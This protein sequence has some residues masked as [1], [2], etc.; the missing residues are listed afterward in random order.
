MRDRLELPGQGAKRLLRFDHHRKHLQSREEA[1]A[2]LDAGTHR[3]IDVMDAVLVRAAGARST[4]LSLVGLGIG[5]NADIM[6]GVD[7]DLK[8]RAGW[9]AY[10]FSG[11]RAIRRA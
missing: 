4:E 1:V 3:D 11:A 9:M 10:V 6:A 8:K 2:I 7:E 5:Y